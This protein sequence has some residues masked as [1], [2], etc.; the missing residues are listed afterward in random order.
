MRGI[1][2]EQKTVWR[3]GK[4]VGEFGELDFYVSFSHYEHVFEFWRTIS[5]FS[6]FICLEQGI[7]ILGQRILCGGDC[8]VQHSVF[9]NIPGL[10]LLNASGTPSTSHDNY[11]CL[12]TL[13]HV[14]WE[15][16]LSPLEK[17]WFRGMKHD[18]AALL[19]P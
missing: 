10:Y 5:Y 4:G 15:G 14:S 11:R 3:Y 19:R 18:T 16:D 1:F 13:P 12:R 2:L 9:H 6:G 8:P 7:D 17:P